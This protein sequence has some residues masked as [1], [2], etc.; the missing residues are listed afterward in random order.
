LPLPVGLVRDASGQVHKDPDLEVQARLDL[1]FSTFL[2]LKAAGKVLRFFNDHDLLIP[3]H[4]RF[5]DLV[6]KKPTV[7]AILAT[8]KNPAYAGAFVYG[9]T[10]TR[11]D[12]SGRCG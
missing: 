12:A 5:G 10:S 6:W 3:R 11:R 2:Q 1:I 8:L 7:A 9:R 4:D